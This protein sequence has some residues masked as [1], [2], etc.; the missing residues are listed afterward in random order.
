MAFIKFKPIATQFRFFQMVESKDLEEEVLRYVDP[1][2][3]IILA[4]KSKRD[5]GIFTDKRLVLIDKKGIRGFRESIYA[6]KYD[7][8]TTYILNIH[9]FDS[10]IEM[11]TN[12]AHKLKVSLLKP[13]PL[14]TVYVIYE[15][16]T[17]YIIKS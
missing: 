8:I 6:I 12:G 17:N 1:N 2:E 4:V 9:N 11:I 3:K 16:L 14:D 10:T 15:Y 7:N 5:Y 13:I